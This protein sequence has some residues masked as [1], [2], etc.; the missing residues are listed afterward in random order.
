MGEGEADLQDGQRQREVERVRRHFA[1]ATAGHVSCSNDVQ[2]HFD[3]PASAFASTATVVPRAQDG[4]LNIPTQSK[5]LRN[6]NNKPIQKGPML[7]ETV[8]RS[9]PP[10]R[11]LHVGNERHAAGTAGPPGTPASAA[12]AGLTG[13]LGDPS[14]PESFLTML[15]TAS[16]WKSA[17]CVLPKPLNRRH[18][19]TCAAS[20]ASRS[21]PFLAAS[22]A[23]ASAHSPHTHRPEKRRR[24]AAMYAGVHSSC[25]PQH[26]HCASSTSDKRVASPPSPPSWPPSTTSELSSST[27]LP[28]SPATQLRSSRDDGERWCRLSPLP[29]LPMIVAKSGA[30]AAIAGASPLGDIGM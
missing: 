16:A 30:T 14:P 6:A 22:S 17:G 11:G 10:D 5:E 15:M 19:A 1:M 27:S 20:A 2:G 3:R 26:S 7:L 9:S 28:S 12:A 29:K 23:T 25:M 13:D 21:P 4:A 8:K 24:T 18:T